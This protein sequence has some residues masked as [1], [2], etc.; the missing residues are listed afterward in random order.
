M[1]DVSKITDQ[2]YIA[3]HP[4]L[5]HKDEVI[6]LGVK[7]ILCMI[8]HPP[9]H[10]YWKEPFRLKWLPNF[11][12]PFFPISIIMLKIGVRE[13]LRT[14]EEGG[15]VL[16]Y[17]REGRHRSVAMAC[18]ILIGLGYS[19]SDAME[20]VKNKRALADPDIWYIKARIQKFEQVWL[21]VRN[22]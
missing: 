16:V 8:F 18:C 9:A 4:K 22:K 6:Q 15:S 11:D 21:D 20:L 10:V 12:A 19:S 5:K 17:C 13:A 2:L 1:I 7:L 3:A 14:I